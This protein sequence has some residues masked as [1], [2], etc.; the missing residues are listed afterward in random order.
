MD[1]AKAVGAVLKGLTKSAGADVSIARFARF[2]IGEK[3]G[4]GDDADA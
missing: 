2:A 4:E 3:A 1:T